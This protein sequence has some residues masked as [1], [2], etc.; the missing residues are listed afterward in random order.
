MT[1]LVLILSRL[2]LLFWPLAGLAVLFGPV[3]ALLALIA[4]E[5]L[6]QTLS[7]MRPDPVFFGR[8]R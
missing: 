7:R 3:V 4:A 5:A 1:S 6:V 2:G 8:T